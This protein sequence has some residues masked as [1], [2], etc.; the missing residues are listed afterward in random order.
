MHSIQ[1]LY[2]TYKDKG[3]V[4]LS[5]PC[6]QFKRQEPKG[7]AEIEKHY[8]DTYNITFPILE[9]GDV[10]GSKA[11]RWYQFVKQKCPQTGPLG[12]SRIT[13]NFTKFL[14]DKKGIPRYR[15]GISKTRS[16]MDKQVQEL[17]NEK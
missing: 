1:K 2:D 7:N 12:L 3:L 15:F 8:Q 10:N 13:W 14:I 4:I 17:L 5:R 16:H 9:K 11:P 6:N